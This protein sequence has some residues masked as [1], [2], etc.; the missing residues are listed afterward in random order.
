MKAYFI[1][2]VLLLFSVPAVSEST[3]RFKKGKLIKNE[4]SATLSVQEHYSAATEAFETKQGGELLRQARIVIRN[5]PG[6]PFADEAYYYM[7]VGYFWTEEWELSSRF[8]T[9]YL[10]KNSAPKFFEEAI[11]YKFEIAQHYSS[12]AKKHVFGFQSLPKWIPARHE[13]I[14]IYDEVIT[15]LPHHELSA[16]SL[17]G[18]AQLLLAEE[19]YK[20]SIDTYQ[21]LI[22]RFPCH[23]LAADAYIGIAQ[24]YLAQSQQSYPDQDFLDL[25]EINLQKFLLAFPRVEKGVLCKELFAQMQEVYAKDFYDTARFYERTKKPSAASIYYTYI[26]AKYPDT[27]VALLARKRQSQLPPSQEVEEASPDQALS[28]ERLQQEGYT[29]ECERIHEAVQ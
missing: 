7:G 1:V 19:E 9:R 14:A 29:L 26:M 27:R 3:Y 22:R 24:V 6:T 18:K 2:I 10:K 28:S 16:Q 17:F 23:P 13:A 15:A 21:M 5:F 12:G 20:S 25:A 8:L 4:E 11:R